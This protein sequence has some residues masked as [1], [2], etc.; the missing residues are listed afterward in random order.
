MNYKLIGCDE[1][2]CSFEI[3]SYFSFWTPDAVEKIQMFK[4][5]LKISNEGEPKGK[6]MKIEGVSNDD[7]NDLYYSRDQLKGISKIFHSGDTLIFEAKLDLVKNER[8]ISVIVEPTGG[9]SGWNGGLNMVNFFVPKCFANCTIID[10]P[11]TQPPHPEKDQ[12]KKPTG[13]KFYVRGTPRGSSNRVSKKIPLDKTFYKLHTNSPQSQ[14]NFSQDRSFPQSDRNFPQSDRN[15]PQL[16]RNHLQPNERVFQSDGNYSRSHGNFSQQNRDYLPST[17]NFSA[18]DRNYQSPN[19]NFS[20]LDW[21]YQS[22]NQ[23]FSHL[24]RNYQSSSNQNFSQLSRD[25]EEPGWNLLQSSRN[26]PSSGDGFSRRSSYE[27]ERRVY[28]R[29]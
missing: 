9:T 27:E 3:N 24:D 5:E 15:Y 28:R 13:N 22:T 4:R 7:E 6:K 21:N 14:G 18:V 2:K 20:H 8:N 12:K 19:Q 25:R 10:L 23:N 17:S 1:L 29:N 26:Y 16:D 11:V